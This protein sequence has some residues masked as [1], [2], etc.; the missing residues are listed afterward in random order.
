MAIITPKDLASYLP[1][2]NEAAPATVF[3]ANLA[4]DVVSEVTGPLDPV[5]VRVKAI[6]LE[7][8]ARGLR[9]S[10]GF[11]SVTTS[12]DDTTKTWRR[13]TAGAAAGVFLTDAEQNE[14][15]AIV[16]NRPLT[17]AFTIR[18]GARR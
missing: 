13:D 6:A 8:A 1:G 16:S 7:V 14:L 9:G 4:N 15:R 11:T 18:P 12:T 5:P 17:D 3:Y 2:T 10:D